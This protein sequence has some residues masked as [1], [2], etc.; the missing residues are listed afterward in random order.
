MHVNSK[1]YHG[2]LKIPLAIH[3]AAILLFIAI[4]LWNG[5]V[6]AYFAV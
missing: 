2:K 1:L 3:L 4:S 6:E 5:P